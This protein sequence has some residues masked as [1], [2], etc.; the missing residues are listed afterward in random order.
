[1]AL[2]QPPSRA[3]VRPTI[4]TLPAGMD[5][6]NAER[7]GADLRAAFAPGVTVVVAD[8]TATT[9]CDSLGIRAL[10]RAHQRAAAS[11]AELRLV[12]PSARVMR[13]LAVLGLDGLLAIHPSLQEALPAEPAAEPVVVRFPAEFGISSAGRDGRTGSRAARR[14]GSYR[15]GAP[16]SGRAALLDLGAAAE[17]VRPAPG[18]P[19]LVRAGN[20]V[21]VM[22]P[23]GTRG[24][25][26]ESDGADRL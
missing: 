20:L 12:V 7:V 4:A 10:V 22:R 18:I 13:L 21:R 23:A 19:V 1:M 11:D 16:L 14:P 24:S 6:T 2:A 8:M 26:R 3:T 9:F 5:V 15:P 25:R 17:S